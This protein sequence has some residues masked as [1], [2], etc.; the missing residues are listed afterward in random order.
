MDFPLQNSL[1]QAFKEKD[2]KYSSRGF[3]KLY[4]ALANDFNYASP[5]NIMVFGDNH[6]M[7]RIYTQLDKNLAFT[8]MA[9]TF[10]MTTRGI[11]EVYYGTEILMDNTGFPGNHGVIRSDFPGGWKSDSQDAVTGRGLSQDQL[12]M[13]DYVKQLLNWRKGNHV[14]SSGKLLHFAPFDGLYVYFRYTDDDI[15]MVVMNK[16]NKEMK[17]D[18]SR[19]NEI[20]KNRTSAT[21]VMTKASISLD[22]LSV[23]SESAT[24]FSLR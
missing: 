4:E 22:Q 24:I 7:D 17:I 11:P 23:P 13:K 1:V 3:I 20:I 9:F 19:F 10:F 8:K 16:N 6:D 21:N 2:D 18:V 12:E 15:I 14:I 5:E